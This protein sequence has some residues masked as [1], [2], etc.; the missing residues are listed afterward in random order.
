MKSKAQLIAEVKRLING[1]EGELTFNALK[2][3]GIEATPQPN[4]L[5]EAIT[6]TGERIV[7]RYSEIKGK[8]TVI[9]WGDGKTYQIG[10]LGELVIHVQNKETAENLVKLSR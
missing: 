2:E 7:K 5:F 9:A 1:R 4:D 10:H 6:S 3:Y 8:L